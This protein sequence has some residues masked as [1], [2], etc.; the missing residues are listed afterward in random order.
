MKDLIDI[1]LE[2]IRDNYEAYQECS[3]YEECGDQCSHH[4]NDINIWHSLDNQDDFCFYKNLYRKND[5]ILMDAK[6][7]YTYNEEPI[8]T[9]KQIKQIINLKKL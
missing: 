8:I 4:R 1:I 6:K 5:N 9:Y 2:V 7:F 3:S